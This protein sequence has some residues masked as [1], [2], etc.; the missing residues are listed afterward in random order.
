MNFRIADTFTAGLGRLSGDEQKA[1]KTT[2]FDLQMD[3]TGPGMSFHKLDKT[4]D[5]AFWSVRASRDLRLIVHRSGDNLLLCFVGHHDDAYA[6]AERR[7]LETHPTT[8]AAQMVELVERVEEVDA[9][10]AKRAE[11]RTEAVIDVPKGEALPFASRT[12]AELLSWGV[13]PDWLCAVR[14][15]DE[16]GILTLAE[17]LPAEAAEAAFSRHGGRRSLAART[18]SPWDRWTVFLHPAQR[19]WVEREHSGPARVS[20]SAGTGKTIVALHRAVHLARENE[21]ARVL[22]TTFSEPLASTLQALLRRLIGTTPRL[23]ERIDIVALDTLADRLYGHAFGKAKLASDDD[24]ARRLDQALTSVAEPRAPAWLYGVPFLLAEWKEVVDAW[25]IGSLDAYRGARRLGRRTRLAATQREAVWPIFAAAN[26]SLAQDGLTTRAARYVRLAKHYEGGA[27]R[28]FDFIVVDE[29]QDVSVPQL[30]LLAALGAGRPN[31]LFF[32]GDTAQRIFEQPFSWRS[33]G[34]EVRGRAK[35]LRVNYRTSHQIRSQAD[36]LLGAE[37]QDVDGNVEVRSSTV[38]VFDGP[39]PALRTFASNAAEREGVAAWLLAIE[40]AGLLAAEIGIFVRSGGQI[41]RARDACESAGLAFSVLDSRL[42]TETGGVSIGTMHQAKGLEFRVVAVMAC[43]DEV[44]PL[45][46]RI[47][48]IVDEGDLAAVYESERQLLYV[49]VT[50]ARDRLLVCGVD[51]A[52]E[53]LR[54]LT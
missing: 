43:D 23:G 35:T 21:D 44:L 20:G 4:R 53:F 46:E 28:P 19:E 26:R 11:A 8:G 18:R 7:R 25:Q 39:A 49:A 45:Q 34:V 48:G 33:L 15:A 22:L 10:R 24:I 13:P 40:R 47:D 9:P 50:R 27:K 2:A 52:S 38:S 29:A 36:R 12:D 42:D 30:R 5:R 17:R 1:A 32:A 54:D 51:P 41:E 6:W 16:D 37:V 14:E 31:G 3:P